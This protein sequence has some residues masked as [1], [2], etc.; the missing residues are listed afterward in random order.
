MTKKQTQTVDPDT[1]PAIGGIVV[2]GEA[3]ALAKAQA[4]ALALPIPVR[5]PTSGRSKD[6]LDDTD[7][8][9]ARLSLAQDT[10]PQAKKRE[11]AYIEGL[12]PGMFFNSITGEIY[13]ETVTIAVVGLTKRAVMLDED[14]KI[15][16]RGLSWTDDRC[17]SPGEDAQ[18]KWIKPEATRIY[19][20]LV[21]RVADGEPSLPMAMSCKKTAFKAGKRFNSLLQQTKGEDW[22][23]LYTVSAQV[24]VGGVNS[25]F[26]PKFAYVAMSAE[27]RKAPEAVVE[28][29]SHLFDALS[30]GRVQEVEDTVDA[31]AVDDGVPF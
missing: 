19:D 21:V 24:E 10:T 13:G 29:C 9:P 16:E 3:V 31:P 18:G 6:V 28:Y 25:Y 14:G 2:E 8:Y 26:V 11:D 22:E 30:A 15:I 7:I 27:K 4:H 20:Y 23:T 1:A 5:R 17:I 12:E